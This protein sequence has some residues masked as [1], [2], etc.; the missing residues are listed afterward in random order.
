MHVSNQE[1]FPG[2]R[3]DAEMNVTIDVS[4]VE[5][6][7]GRVGATNVVAER[8]GCISPLGELQLGRRQSVAVEH[9]DTLCAAIRIALRGIACCVSDFFCG[10]VEYFQ[11][12]LQ[13]VR[14]GVDQSAVGTIEQ[15]L[16]ADAG[17]Y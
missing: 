14:L 5:H 12:G 3:V 9:A 15:D 11:V 10:D 6:E 2:G 1:S 16:V 13:V 4:G 17:R 8:T 7:V